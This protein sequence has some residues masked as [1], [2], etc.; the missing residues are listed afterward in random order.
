MPSTRLDQLLVERGLCESRSLAQRIIMAG[1]VRV[2]GELVLKSSS[3]FHDEVDIEIV[4]PAPYVSRGGEKL[5][6]ALDAFPVHVKGCVC[7]DIGASTGGFTDCLLQRGATRV[8][9]I[10]VGK[11]IL[12]WKLRQDPRVIVMEKTNVRYQDSLP[13]PVNLITIDV[14]FISLKIILPVIKNWFLENRWIQFRNG[15]KR[16]VTTPTWN[17]LIM[18][19]KPQFEAGKTDAAKGRGVI[20]DPKI[21]HRVLYDVLYYAKEQ[22]YCIHD[23]IPSPIKGPKGNMEF[24]A[25]LSYQYPNIESLKSLDLEKELYSAVE[26]DE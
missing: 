21:H 15:Q 19:I 22:G 5:A 4:K 13:E 17:Q 23:V 24:L 7:A 6:A 1:Q 2:K 10:D 11:G 3:K 12:H 25:W 18:L 14:S 26:A 16:S 9:A 8:Y 20:R